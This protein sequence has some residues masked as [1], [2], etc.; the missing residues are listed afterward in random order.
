[1]TKL[2]VL[3]RQASVGTYV[4]LR[5]TRGE[6]VSGRI[7]ELD[8]TH[9]CLALGGKKV[10]VFEDILAGWEI[11]SRDPVDPA[12]EMQGPRPTA[13]GTNDEEAT[14]EGLRWAALGGHLV[15]DVSTK[16]EEARERPGMSADSPGPIAVAPTLRDP[17]TDHNVLSTLARIEAAFSEALKRA[18]LE[19]LEPDFAFPEAV[20][21]SRVVADVRREWDR[22]RSQYAYAL[23]I[24]EMN[25]LNSVVMQVLDPLVQHYPDS[26]ALRSLL[27]QVLLKIHRQPEAKQH[28]AEAARMSEAPEHWLALA[29]AAGEDSAVEC[30]ALRRYFGLTPPNRMKEGWFRFLAVAIDNHDQSSASRVI[31]Y[32]CEHEEADDD[33]IR[34]LS[35]SA[36]YLLSIE[37]E[38]LALETT[39]SLVYDEAGLP[40][41]W[42]E[43]FNRRAPLSENLLKVESEFTRRNVLPATPTPARPTR[44]KGADRIPHGRIMSFGNQRFGFIDTHWGETFFFRIDDVA[45]ARLQQ[46]LLDGSWRSIGEVEFDGFPSH[47]YKYS[48][49]ANVIPFQDAEALIERARQH[50][51][52]N[53]HSQAMAFIR[54]ALSSD[55]NH[56]VARKFEEEIKQQIREQGIGLPKGRGPYARAKRAQLVD[57]DLDAAEKLLREAIRS[58]DKSESAI[59]D[60]ASLLQQQG[61]TDDA[62][63]LLEEKSRYHKDVSPY[64]NMLATLYMQVNRNDNAIKVLKRLVNTTQTSERGPLLRRIAFSYFKS[65]R[66][67]DS[68]RVLQELLVCNPDDRTAERW[69]AGLE[70]AR[71]A[72]SYQEAE[73]IIGEPGGL[74][75]ESVELSSL[76]RA[77]IATC[78]FEGV[79]PAKVQAATVGSKDIARL[80]DL[81]KQ[82]G[83]KRPRDRAAYYLSAAALLEREP[84]EKGP[85]RIYDYLRRYFTSMADASWI[86][87]KSAD[88]VRAYY[89]ESL[90]LVFDDRLDEAWRSLHRYLASFSPESLAKVEALL[91]R[92]GYRG[93]QRIYPK[94]YGKALTSTLV[95]LTE[96]LGSGWFE[97]LFVLGS[98]S[99]FARRHIG[100]A[101]KAS[102]P[103][104]AALA[105]LVQGS[106]LD[107]DTVKQAWQSRCRDCARSH[108]QRLSVCQTLTKYQATVASME[109]LHAQLRG[110]AEGTGSEID[111]R[112]LNALGDIVD[113]ALGFCRSA[114]FEERE[115]SYWLV[116][117]QADRFRKEID[118]APTQYSHE[119]LLPISDHLK[120]LIE[121][122]YA[123]MA[124]TSGAELSLRLLVEQYLRGQK[125]ELRLQI[126]ISNKRGCSPA[127]SV[128]ICLGP[129]DSEYFA[130]DRWEQAVVTTLRGDDT[131]VAQ[132]LIYPK[133]LALG[134]RAFPI[135][136]TA[137]Y[138]NR[139]GEEKRTS[140]HSWTVRLYS[141]EEFQRI[142]NPYAPFAGGGPVD[143]AEMF[144]GRDDLLSRLENSLLA[145][146]GSKSIVM[147]GQKR[148]G[149]SSLLEHL[150]RRLDLREG[151]V[152]VCFSLQDIAPELSMPALLYRI[153]QGTAEVLE[154][155]RFAGQ[156]VPEFYPPGIQEL[157]DH[158]T[159]RFHDAMSLLVRARKRFS[160]GFSFVLLVDE[161]TDIF[162]EIR[163]G[164]IPREFMKAWKAIIEKRYFAS[165]L[166]GQ[167]IMPAFKAE[168]PNEFGVTEDVR[169]TYLDVTSAA[170]LIQKPIGERRF[171]GNAV[172]RLF[173]LTAGSPYYTM[174]FCALLV[175]YMNMTRSAIVTEADILA[176][177]EE[178]LRGDRRLT[179]DKFDNLICAGD[180]AVDSGIEPDDTYAVCAA[181][182]QGSVRGW[183]A[184]DV[185]RCFKGEVLDGLLADLE[186][187]DVVERKGTAYRLRVG[188]FQDWLV[189]QG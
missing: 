54:R 112:R 98:H 70:D 47:G 157:E 131:I 82:L 118:G 168:F 14:G 23:K 107:G 155:R 165:V 135:E 67:D 40:Q 74:A 71:R 58:R 162:K 154:E 90:A 4:T 180:G 160:S 145:G 176:V 144:V 139:L 95:M 159:L 80:E 21:S 149:K 28:L 120:S 31:H 5:L 188:L 147:F 79:D 181:I 105:G 177:E 119:G 108:R 46:A 126:E 69:L 88:V 26:A 164:R 146:S 83:T 73:E 115:R 110:A 27:G 35:E 34:L 122:E 102:Q 140:G 41:G 124:R 123:Q 114:E 56:A 106:N 113:A 167:D 172:G 53:Q 170:R 94:D 61:R 97:K 12:A 37:S 38:P 130:A 183:C 153:L 81:A 142:D 103:L 77:A 174:M 7:A 133:P 104:Q 121:E 17:A 178:M 152:P 64:D 48:R 150:R 125:G 57:Q 68:E 78:T 33:L 86:E 148:A 179:R 175:D 143:D 11:H 163:K 89:M 99:G 44:S 20:F 116:T 87:K 10:T 2:E 127:S 13:L 50:L 62:I 24:N 52:A 85:A 129:G 156:D 101:I 39:A 184:R 42:E 134:D 138:H 16:T 189:M 187:R 136:A 91:P 84:D 43:I 72:G 185:V 8:D 22:A 166:V 76:A 30:Y 36:V 51:K 63:A 25:R 3:R 109:D 49:A 75:E 141:D 151:V 111:R 66:Y 18:R 100:E 15:A 137:I 9:V 1:M 169:V 161:F 128:R 6:D 173:D 186:R 92:A 132:M 65:G 59:K 117:T 45:D 182:A 158:A 55:E 171:A 32:W 93:P 60:L 29:S 19:P 96:E